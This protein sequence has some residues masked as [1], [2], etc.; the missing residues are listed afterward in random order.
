[1]SYE[2]E[3]FLTT[4]GQLAQLSR[5]AAERAA[6]RRAPCSRRCAVPCPARSPAA[7]FRQGTIVTAEPNAVPSAG[8]TAMCR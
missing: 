3:H 7:R 5:E 4:V 8:C 1:M 6:S 2:Q